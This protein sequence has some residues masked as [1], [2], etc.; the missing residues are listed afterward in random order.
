MPGSRRCAKARSP[1]ACE[2]NAEER[3]ALARVLDKNGASVTTG[4]P[5]TMEDVVAFRRFVMALRKRR[6][7]LG[8]SLGDVSQATGIDKS[9]LSRLETGEQ[10]NPTVRTLMR[11]ARA[12]GQPL[13]WPVSTDGPPLIYAPLQA[14]PRPGQ[15][16]RGRGIV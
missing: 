14:A 8:L 11:Y 4:D 1:E 6:E 3:A 9:A 10:L 12:V 2:T 13:A 16:K 5:G 7:A 15:S